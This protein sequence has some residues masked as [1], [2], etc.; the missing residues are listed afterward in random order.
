MTEEELSQYRAIKQEIADLNKR[1]K[2]AK[3]G[4]VMSFGTVKGSSKYF[5]YTPQTFHVTG[6]DPADT[7][8]RQ[9]QISELLRQREVKRNEL[10]KKQLDIEQ[11]ISEISDSTTRTIFRMHFID[12][13]NQI[14]IGKTLGYD[15]SV[16]SRKIRSYVKLHKI[17]NTK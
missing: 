5:P 6:M 15:Q 13:D 10:I 8:A 1:I 3:E 9:K 2:D 12:G 11:Y 4:P 14:K 17:H 16:V 7:D